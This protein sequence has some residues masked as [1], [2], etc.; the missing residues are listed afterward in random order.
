MS[1]VV[2]VSGGIG[3]IAADF[4]QLAAF[5]SALDGAAD[6]IA[7]MLGML[8]RRLADPALIGAAVLDPAGA[9]E[10]LALAGVTTA[11]AAAT[12]AGCQS[13]SAGLRLAAGS[14]RA[15][16]GLDRRMA[17][18][19]GAGYRLPLALA[20]FAGSAAPSGVGVQAGLSADPALVGVA[21]Q[22]LTFAG[23]GGLP[24][25]GSTARLAGLLATPFPDGAAEVSVRPAAPTGDAG[26]PPRGA[27]DLMRALALRGSHN[28]GGGSIDV[29]TL[30]GAGGRRV[31]VDITGTTMWNFDP[32][33][34]TPEVSDV[35]TN[36]RALANRSSVFE[37][38]VIQALRL[39]GVSPGEP[40]MLVGHSQ[41]GMIAA[42]LAGE[43]QAAGY[44][45]THLVT[46]GSPIAWPRCPPRCRCCRCRTKV[47]WCPSWTA[48]TTPSA[49]TG[50]PYG[51]ITATARCPVG[52]RC[53]PTW[54]ELSTSTPAPTQ[55]WRTGAAARPASSTPTGSAPRSSRSGA[56]ADGIARDR[57]V[58]GPPRG[59]ARTPRCSR[60]TRCLG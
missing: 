36:L 25:P 2:T 18:V 21:V 12:L 8:A 16:D 10:I 35:G 59:C 15:V 53:A 29:R 33:R 9:A 41:G 47:M 17:P 30:D 54:P 39:A 1:G 31:I 26:G 46:A 7:G 50:S 38:G 20:P 37:R 60:I 44:T 40:I 19:L 24:L 49:R 13:L 27:A 58:A 5:A 57:A 14:Y 3:S 34:R 45:V 28:D 43:L 22:L 11:G 52:T 23:S 4:E 55:R 42:R 32:G 51:P 6:S 56:R 48:R